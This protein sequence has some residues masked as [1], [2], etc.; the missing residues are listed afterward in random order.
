MRRQ[1]AFWLAILTGALMILWAALFARLQM[2][3]RDKRLSAVTGT[4]SNAAH[5][6]RPSNTGAR[7]C[8]LQRRLN[9][10]TRT[11]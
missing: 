7:S 4:L 5:G 2:P 1:T 11:G 9:S 8:E 3:E 10:L 6:S